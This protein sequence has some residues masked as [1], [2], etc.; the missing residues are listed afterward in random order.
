M[1]C[2]LCVV[3]IHRSGIPC[4]SVLPSCSVFQKQMTNTEVTA[5]AG[6]KLGNLSNLLFR[7]SC[8]G[9]PGS[10]VTL[11]R[12]YQ[13]T[14]C[15]IPEDIFS[16]NDNNTTKGQRCFRNRRLY[17]IYNVYK[18]VCLCLLWRASF[19]AIIFTCINDL[20]KNLACSIETTA[21]TLRDPMMC[22]SAEGQK[23]RTITSK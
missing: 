4:Q 9:S 1:E 3:G 10:Y 23:R 14:R 21:V 18:R 6:T 19:S 22:I 17:F 5:T 16:F 8:A 20:T 12:F 11:I 2:V 13:T 15:H 7:K